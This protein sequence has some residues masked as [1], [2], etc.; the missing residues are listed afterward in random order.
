MVAFGSSL[1]LCSWWR[2]VTSRPLPSTDA[3]SVED[4]F[5]AAIARVLREADEAERVVCPVLHVVTSE[6]DE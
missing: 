2:H 3:T 1:P 5:W 4:P 6:G